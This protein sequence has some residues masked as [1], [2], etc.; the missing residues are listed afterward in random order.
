M[1]PMMPQMKIDEKKLNPVAY[2][3]MKVF[4]EHKI[5]VKEAQ[6]VF[7]LVNQMLMD[8]KLE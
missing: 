5:T 3:V 2:D 6:Q 1:Q 7:A 8:T 4:K